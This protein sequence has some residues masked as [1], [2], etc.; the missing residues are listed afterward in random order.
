MEH[1]SKDLDEVKEQACVYL[2]RQKSRP[3]EQQIQNSG[4]RESWHTK[5]AHIFRAE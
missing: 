2:G 1:L 3:R 4:A 5:E